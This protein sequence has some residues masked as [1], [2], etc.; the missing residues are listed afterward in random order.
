[1]LATMKCL[2]LD[3][4]VSPAEADL[5]HLGMNGFSHEWAP[6]SHKSCAAPPLPVISRT[7]GPPVSYGQGE[8]KSGQPGLS[9]YNN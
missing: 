1:M 5:E 6:Q 7:V 8:P 3:K 9:L 2:R 4:S